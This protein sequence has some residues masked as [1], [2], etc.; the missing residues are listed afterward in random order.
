MENSI[1][2]WLRNETA[3]WEWLM[4]ALE[5]CND[6]KT[7]KE[8]CERQTGYVVTFTES[9]GDDKA[10]EKV[11]RKRSLRQQKELE[12]LRQKSDEQ[13]QEKDVFINQKMMGY[14]RSY[15]YMNGIEST[16]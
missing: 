1:D 11:K 3:T 16:F 13:F 4:V 12:E 8:I 6:K 7:A 10:L 2:Y 14:I 9:A 5:K 15:I